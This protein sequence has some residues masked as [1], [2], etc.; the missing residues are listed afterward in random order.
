MKNICKKI[1]NDLT[2]TLPGGLY[3]DHI[4]SLSLTRDPEN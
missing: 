2:P 1:K 4:F 3:E